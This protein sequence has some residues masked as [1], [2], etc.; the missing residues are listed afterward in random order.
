MSEKGRQLLWLPEKRSDNSYHLWCWKCSLLP[1]CGF[2][3]TQIILSERQ[4]FESHRSLKIF[5]LLL[6]NCENRSPLTRIIISLTDFHPQVNEIYFIICCGKLLSAKVFL[7]L[8]GSNLFSQ[9]FPV[10]K[11][12]FPWNDRGQDFGSSRLIDA[13]EISSVCVLKFT[14]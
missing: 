8:M 7:Q 10:S 6:C 3:T 2:V 1:K 13:L 5:Y 14:I 11:G 12:A 9:K 4:R